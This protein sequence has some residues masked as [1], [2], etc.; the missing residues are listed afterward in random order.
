MAAI[1]TQSVLSG[2]PRF[3]GG[4]ILISNQI[5]PDGTTSAV[6]D[7]TTPLVLTTSRPEIVASIDPGDNRKVIITANIAPG[8][9]Q[10]TGS[11]GVNTNPPLPV[12]MGASISVAISS[13]PDQRKITWDPTQG[14]TQGDA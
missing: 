8:S 6:V 3:I 9:P 11:V 1:P 13:A 2:H 5:N 4:F 10:V 12:N 7:T 14:G